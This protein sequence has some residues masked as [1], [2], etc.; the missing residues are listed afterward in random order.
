[1]HTLKKFIKYYGPYKTVFFL[2]LICATVI[3][4]VDLAF[5]QILRTLT[6]TLFTRDTAAI[7]S[8]LIPY[9]AGSAHNVH[10]PKPLQ[11]LRQ[12][13]RSHDGCKYGKGYASAAL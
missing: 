5:P 3:S 1:M 10:N 8:A 7:V 13:P 9:R 2:D 4:A 6:R 11:I 12:L